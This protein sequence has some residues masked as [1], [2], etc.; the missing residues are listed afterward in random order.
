MHEYQAKVIILAP[1]PA[2]PSHRLPLPVCEPS[3]IR[4]E[5]RR[6]DEHERSRVHHPPGLG[7]PKSRSKVYPHS[8]TAS[9]D[10]LTRR[11]RRFVVEEHEEEEEEPE[12]ERALPPAASRTSSRLGPRSARRQSHSPASGLPEPSL[13]GTEAGRGGSRRGRMSVAAGPSSAGPSGTTPRRR[14]SEWE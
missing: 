3:N 14:K 12:V 7:S 6:R 11:G 2:F 1:L 5:T 13:L 10:L 4:P 9:R 8:S